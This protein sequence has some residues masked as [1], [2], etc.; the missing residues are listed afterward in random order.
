MFFLR[1]TAQLKGEDLIVKA[2]ST[3]SLK[4]EK[5]RKISKLPWEKNP[6]N[7]QGIRNKFCVYEQIPIKIDEFNEAEGKEFNERIEK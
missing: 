5:T 6:H 3:L 4:L 2:I 7:Y 1:F